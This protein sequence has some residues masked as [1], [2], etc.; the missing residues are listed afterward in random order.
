MA[1]CLG[2]SVFSITTKPISTKLGTKHPWAKGIKSNEGPCLFP[3][4]DNKEIAKY[5]N[6]IRNL[7]QTTGPISTKLGTKHQWVKGI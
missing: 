1:S 3:S 7:F 2:H 5:M 6:V 4:E